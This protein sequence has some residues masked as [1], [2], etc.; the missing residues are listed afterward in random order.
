MKSARRFL[1]SG[2]VQGVGYRYFVFKRAQERS[3][4]GYVLNLPDGRVEILA[5]GSQEALDALRNDLEVGPRFSKVSQVEQF[6]ADPTG[7]FDSF[8]ITR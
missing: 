6:P 1:V 2:L 4:S 7:R 5:E 8:S 3:V